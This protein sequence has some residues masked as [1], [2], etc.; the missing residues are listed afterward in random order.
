M[1]RDILFLLCSLFSISAVAQLSPS[2]RIQT[3]SGEIYQGIIIEQTPGASIKLLRTPGLDT[4]EVIYS[5]IERIVKVFDGPAG[6]GKAT[7][8]EREYI[9]TGPCF[10]CR[11]TYVMLHFFGAGGDEEILY[12]GSGL[13]FGYNIRNIVQIGLGASLMGNIEA[14]REGRTV[15]PLTLD[16]RY[17]FSKSRS[18]RGAFLLGAASGVSVPMYSSD[19]AD[20]QPKT[21]LFFSGTFGFRFNVTSQFGLLLDFGYMP[22]SLNFYSK[23]SGEHIEHKWYQMGIVRG[24]VF[25]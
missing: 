6:G 3:K 23:G 12:V 20:L 7:V 15:V 14:K 9:R 13:S 16:I 10:N 1:Y 4:I 8:T 5:D 22:N 25:F 18:G 21:G 11:S 19:Q 2:D 17:V 24:S